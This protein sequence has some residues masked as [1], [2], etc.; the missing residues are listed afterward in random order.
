MNRGAIDDHSVILV[1][2]DIEASH[3]LSFSLRF[4]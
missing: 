2:T 1:E 4:R 3:F